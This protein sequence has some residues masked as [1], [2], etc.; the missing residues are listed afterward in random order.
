MNLRQPETIRLRKFPCTMSKS[1]MWK[2]KTLNLELII[3]LE[4]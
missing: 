4:N 2:V 1:I 3:R